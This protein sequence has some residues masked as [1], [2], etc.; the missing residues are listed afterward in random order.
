MSDDMP[1]VARFRNPQGRLV[2]LR[3]SADGK[4][5][6]LQTW[7]AEHE[8]PEPSRDATGLNITLN[9]RPEYRQSRPLSFGFGLI[10]DEHGVVPFDTS[11]DAG[12]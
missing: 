8:P 12:K 3:R 2:T 10:D 4:R 11:D 9:D 1:E 6:L 7:P 5:E